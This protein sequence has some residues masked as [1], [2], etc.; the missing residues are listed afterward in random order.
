V[1]VHGCAV[2]SP[3]TGCRVT[4]RPRDRFSRYSKWLDTFRTALVHIRLKYCHRSSELH[5]VI[6][7]KMVTVSLALR[8]SYHV[9]VYTGMLQ[10]LDRDFY[11]PGFTY[12]LRDLH[13]SM[14]NRANQ[15]VSGVISDF[16]HEVAENCALLGR[17]AASS[18]LLPTFRDN[19]SVPS[20]GFKNL[21]P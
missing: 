12:F 16:R 6:S 7:M 9:L 11:C 20:Y 14:G 13:V 18:N 1:T 17:Y 19:L 2:R 15:D 21:E 4:S 10:P 3:L 5:G 8:T